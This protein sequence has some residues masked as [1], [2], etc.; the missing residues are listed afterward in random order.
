MLLWWARRYDDAIH[1]SQQALDLST[2]HHV[3]A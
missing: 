1:L 3:N 2:F